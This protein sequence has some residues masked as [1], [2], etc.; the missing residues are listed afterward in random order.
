[1]ELGILKDIVVIFALSTL[2]NFLFTKIRIP[3]IIGYLLTGVIAGPHLLGLLKSPHQIELMAEIG[4]V[5]LMF[6]SCPR[7]V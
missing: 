6:T 5:L 2:V 7:P 3:T 4:V 1:M